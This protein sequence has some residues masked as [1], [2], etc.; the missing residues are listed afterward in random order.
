M[1]P[2][3][4]LDSNQQSTCPQQ[5]ASAP[6]TR[7]HVPTPAAPPGCQTPSGTTGVRFSAALPMWSLR[8]ATASPISDAR[9]PQRLVRIDA[10]WPGS[11]RSG[12]RSRGSPPV[13]DRH[14]S[15]DRNAV[16]RRG[17]ATAPAGAPHPVGGCGQ[18]L[19]ASIMAS[20]SV[21][22]SCAPDTATRRLKMKNGTPVIP[23][24]RASRSASAILAL[25][26][27]EAR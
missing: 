16:R 4:R 25:S 15:A 9:G 1:C 3:T 20:R 19:S 12:R 2:F 26:S 14:V 24:R 27:S 7:K 8:T 18:R 11:L 22:G 23:F 17:L 6:T 10:P 13:A 21:S 5:A